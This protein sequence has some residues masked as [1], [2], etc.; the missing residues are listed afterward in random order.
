MVRW[1]DISRIVRNNKRILDTQIPTP[2]RVPKKKNRDKVIESL[3]SSK[4]PLTFS[5]ILYSSEIKSAGNLHD[6]LR[7]LINDKVISRNFELYNLI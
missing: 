6:V 1:L 7:N 4:Y 2:V 3:E 5:E